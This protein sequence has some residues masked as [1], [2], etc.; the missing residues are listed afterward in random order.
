M[1]FEKTEG[2]EGGLYMWEDLAFS[3]EMNA[4]ITFH[5]I[6]TRSKIA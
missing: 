3:S 1:K 5:S 2:S 4:N 6:H